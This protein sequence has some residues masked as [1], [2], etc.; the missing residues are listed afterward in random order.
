MSVT[1][2]YC[3]AVKAIDGDEAAFEKLRFAREINMNRSYTQLGCSC[4]PKCR[5]IT[6]E[7]SN[8]L[9]DRLETA[10]PYNAKANVQER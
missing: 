2:F 6:E 4:E 3:W 8:T 1:V 5:R 7:E 9:N 10:V